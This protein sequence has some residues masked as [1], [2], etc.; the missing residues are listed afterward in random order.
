MMT[1]KQMGEVLVFLNSVYP[2]FEV[3]QFKIDSWTRILKDNNPAD[4][5]KNAERYALENKFPPTIY[6]I[7]AP[8]KSEAH[9]QDYLAKIRKWEEEASGGPKHKG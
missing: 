5:M 3:T 8:P 1:K 6:D 9:S 4:V 2:N 7:K